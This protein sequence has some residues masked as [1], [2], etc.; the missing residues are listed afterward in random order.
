MPIVRPLT[1]EEE[2]ELTTRFSSALELIPVQGTDADFLIAGLNIV[3]ETVR[4]GR[5]VPRPRDELAVDLGVLWGDELCRVAGWRWCYLVLESGLEGP[6]VCP[7]DQS[8]AVLPVHY[9]HRAFTDV[10]RQPLQLFRKLIDE[11]VEAP[12][13][14]LQL[15]G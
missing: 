8:L 2:A 3:V 5:E 14:A 1:D 6:A 15:L 10:Q 9:I 12:P 7:E 13:G 4:A 11:P